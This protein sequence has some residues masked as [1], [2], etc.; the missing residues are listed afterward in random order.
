[1]ATFLDNAAPGIG[2]LA[3]GYLKGAAA[4]QEKYRQE[5]L[6]R[7]KDA[8][9][10]YMKLIESG[11]WEPVDPE[12]GAKTPG[13]LS[14]G[15]I[16]W[17]QPKE[18]APWDKAKY[19]LEREKMGHEKWKMGQEAEEYGLKRGESALTREHELKKRGLEIQE[20]EA[21][22]KGA[23]DAAA[24]KEEKESKQSYTNMTNG[25][26]IELTDAEYQHIM[27]AHPS[28]LNKQELELREANEKGTLVKGK[29]STI[30]VKP[31]TEI[32]IN[33][34]SMEAQERREKL[35]KDAAEPKVTKEGGMEIARQLNDLILDNSGRFYIWEPNTLRSGGSLVGIELPV[36]KNADGSPWRPTI[37][38]LRQEAKR[39]GRT[40]DSILND[41]IAHMRK[42]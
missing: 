35:M 13:V 2:S 34:Q 25:F 39:S 23:K 11:H 30:S 22:L 32:Q 20:L 31:P 33:R 37:G 26:T 18:I 40:L 42:R 19:E 3:G 36:G 1:M 16:G 17:L 21:R 6:D 4:T 10:T 29:P 41:I 27:T 28:K 38:E 12:K 14:I 24:K 7:G 8:L 15:G 5:E 9:Q